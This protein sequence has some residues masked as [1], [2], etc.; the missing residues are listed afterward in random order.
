MK[1]HHLHLACEDVSSL[2]MIS[3]I[4]NQ[5][6]RCK[7]A[8]SDDA[9]RMNCWDFLCRA[10]ISIVFSTIFFA[11]FRITMSLLLNIYFYIDFYSTEAAL[12]IR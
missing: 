2:E 3:L 10:E 7:N 4:T 11:G 5:N 8:F 1:P 12:R 6:V 9:N